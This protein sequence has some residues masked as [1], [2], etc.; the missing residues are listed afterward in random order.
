MHSHELGQADLTVR[1]AAGHDVDQIRRLATDNGMFAPEEMTGFD[2][3]LQGYLGGALE[4]HRWIVAEGV[5]AALPG[6]AYYAPEP[7]ADR[8]W[9]LYFLA[10]HPQ[11]QRGGIGCALLAQV[12]R[13]LREAGE[14]VARVL[15]VETSG[16]DRYDGARRFYERE[17]FEREARIREFYGPGDDKIVFWKSL[18]Q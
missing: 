12:E 18:L 7:F 14:Q 17:G 13:S 4:G 5:T 8:V 9:N 16:T 10:V 2:E 11:Q 15:I 3:L 1:A 6:A